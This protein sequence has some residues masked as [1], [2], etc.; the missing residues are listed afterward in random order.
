MFSIK[1]SKASGV[2]G[3]VFGSEKNCNNKLIGEIMKYKIEV[4]IAL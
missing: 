4:C 1:Q 3:F 2:G